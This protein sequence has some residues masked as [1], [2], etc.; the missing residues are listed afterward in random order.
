M[1]A[2][3]WSTPLGYKTYQHLCSRK[4]H[5]PGCLTNMI[6]EAIEIMADEQVP[7]PQKEK[8]KP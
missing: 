7:G 6:A 2:G 8:S 4:E 1:S 5:A 3:Y